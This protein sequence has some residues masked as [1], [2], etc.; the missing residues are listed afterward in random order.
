MNR[1]ALTDMSGKWF[2]QDRVQG[3]WDSSGNWNDINVLRQTLYLSANGV[4]IM[5]FVP[6]RDR[7]VMTY[8]AITAEKAA[9]WLIAND[10]DLPDTLVTEAAKSEV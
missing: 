7:E 10:H 2:D 3:E 6:T 1:V 5:Q 4:W 8:E 9:H